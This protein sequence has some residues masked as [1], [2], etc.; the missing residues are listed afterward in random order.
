[1]EDVGIDWIAQSSVHMKKLMF[2]I[3]NDD[4]EYVQEVAQV[5]LTKT[6]LILLTRVEIACL[7][8]SDIYRF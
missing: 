4:R 2:Q 3:E 6:S 5:I 1:M 8:F 7:A